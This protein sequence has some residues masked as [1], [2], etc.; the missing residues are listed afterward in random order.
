M[1][2][3][4]NETGYIPA[5]LIDTQS[6]IFE[7]TLGS[8]G[9][10]YLPITQNNGYSYDFIVNWGDNSLN[11]NYTT[12]YFFSNYAKH[13]YNAGTYKISIRG[14]C[15]YLNFSGV[16]NSANLS[17]TSILQWGYIG[18]AS[19]NHS[20][21][22]CTNLI[23][24]PSGPIT[25][26]DETVINFDASYIFGYCTSLPSIPSQLFLNLSNINTF[27]YSFSYCVGLSSI[28]S[29]LFDPTQLATNFAYT[30]F[31][32]TPLVGNAPTLWTRGN[33]TVSTQC[34][35]GCTNL[36]NYASIPAGWK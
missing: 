9:Y 4:I 36:T 13:Y 32:C 5:S 11:E 12:S 3:K 35:Y 6:F 24:L 28:P 25:G 14:L 21:Y 10:F 22:N 29:T 26:I 2:I 23:S 20:F 7:I 30:F 34:F 17:L 27:L 31:N 8:S 15:Q 1:I 18:I 16:P 33:V 19:L